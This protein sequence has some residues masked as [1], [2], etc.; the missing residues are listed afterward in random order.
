[1]VITA[2]VICGRLRTHLKTASSSTSPSSTAKSS[3]APIAS[4]VTIHGAMPVWGMP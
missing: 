1:M 3:P 4:A 2:L